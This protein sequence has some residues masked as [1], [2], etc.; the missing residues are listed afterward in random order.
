MTYRGGDSDFG[1]Y[2]V[3]EHEG[4]QKIF[5]RNSDVAIG[6]F[7]PETVSC[8][9]DIGVFFDC[10]FEQAPIPGKEK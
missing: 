9:R 10:L 1:E 4:K 8:A 5:I 3:R 2:E 6:E 7:Y